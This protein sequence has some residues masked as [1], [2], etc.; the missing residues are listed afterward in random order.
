MRTCNLVF[1]NFNFEFMYEP[2][3]IYSECGWYILIKSGTILYKNIFKILSSEYVKWF[4]LSVPTLH[5]K[6]SILLQLR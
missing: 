2:F 5:S 1:D 4:I 6:R 3:E